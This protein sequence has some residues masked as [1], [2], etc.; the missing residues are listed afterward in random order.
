MCRHFLTS[1]LPTILLEANPRTVTCNGSVVIFTDNA[2][3]AKQSPGYISVLF[4]P[5]HNICLHVWKWMRLF[6]S[7]F[8]HPF[9]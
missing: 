9:H 4:L 8:L 6:N 3:K 1:S 7:L 2:K 5:H